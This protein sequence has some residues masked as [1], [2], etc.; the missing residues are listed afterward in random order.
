MSTHTARLML[1][2]ALCLSC[3]TIGRASLPV[4]WKKREHD[5]TD[6]A[7]KHVN[8]LRED[9][10]RHKWHFDVNHTT[11][12]EHNDRRKVREFV[13]DR[14]YYQVRNVERVNEVGQRL[15]RI[16]NQAREVFIK[17][18]P[19][20]L[21]V[22][23]HPGPM[24]TEFDWS[25]ALKDPEIHHPLSRES[26]AT[27]AVEALEWNYLL[28]NGKS[29]HAS[30]Q[31][32]LDLVPEKEQKE[33]ASVGLALTE[34]LHT[35]TAPEDQYPTGKPRAE[36][37]KGP[38]PIRAAA[39]GYVSGGERPPTVEALK[40]AL[41][42][43]GPLVASM[44]ASRHFEAYSGGLYDENYSP[45][46]AKGPGNHY[47][48]LVGWDDK[49]GEKGAWRIRNCWGNEWGE[50]GYAWIPYGANHLGAETAWV[51]AASTHYKLPEVYNKALAE[52]KGKD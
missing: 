50:N 37:P 9:V 49:K 23:K 45:K 47:V 36:K 3:A 42:Q 34:L 25:K 8:D 11:V 16:N 33:H 19:N 35:G 43:H 18:H 13:G 30:V 44:Y 41:L 14:Y 28:R 46:D 7:R 1:L 22:V 2:A 52:S 20:V 17:E 12:V 40:K 27:A 29:V 48:I 6:T 15:W 32:V 21:P 51:E 24:A 4:D 5:S 26:W 10:R 31:P 39:W 38:L